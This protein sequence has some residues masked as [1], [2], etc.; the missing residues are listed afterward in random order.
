MKMV[1][2][3]SGN[4][5]VLLTPYTVWVSPSRVVSG[6]GTWPLKEHACRSGRVSLP[7]EYHERWSPSGALQPEHQAFWLYLASTVLRSRT[8]QA[9]EVESVACS[10][11][12]VARII[13]VQA[14]DTVRRRLL[15]PIRA[16][17]PVSRFIQEVPTEQALGSVEWF[18]DTRISL[19]QIGLVFRPALIVPVHPGREVEVPTTERELHF[20]ATST[21]PT[22]S[23][24]VGGVDWSV[25]LQRVK[26]GGLDSSDWG[27][28]KREVFIPFFQ[29]AGE[30]DPEAVLR[31]PRIEKPL[32][33]ILHTLG[34][35]VVIRELKG[36][37]NSLDHV[38]RP[39]SY[40]LKSLSSVRGASPG[41][42][43]HLEASTRPTPS[44][45][46]R[47]VVQSRGDE[48]DLSEDVLTAWIEQLT[49]DEANP[50]DARMALIALERAGYGPEQNAPK[51]E[52][53]ESRVY[54]AARQ[55]LGERVGSVDVNDT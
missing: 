14:T 32:R 16:G 34:S 52:S 24:S 21:Q 25:Q 35:S 15:D 37:E 7:P 20:H 45:S 10:L 33:A 53:L 8:T 9:P 4:G 17:E 23:G 26:Q 48:T 43:S 29:K 51:P 55:A 6:Q 46:S 11:R 19:S 38:D 1:A 5:L 13:G 42:G 54:V 28:W 30:K 40:V 27:E 50:F 31:H 49:G 12:Q 2:P 18:V 3:R 41:V 36:L 22:P 44:P 39:I 47:K